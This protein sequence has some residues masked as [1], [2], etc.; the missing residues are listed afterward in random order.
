MFAYHVLSQCLLTMYYSKSF[1]FLLIK[2]Y[3]FGTFQYNKR[4]HGLTDTL[5]FVDLSVSFPIPKPSTL[6]DIF[7]LDKLINSAGN[8]SHRLKSGH[9]KKQICNVKNGTIIKHNGLYIHNYKHNSLYIE[10]VCI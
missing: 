5:Y 3:F 10:N 9:Q 7:L 4:T 2:K 1:F 6:L 8:I